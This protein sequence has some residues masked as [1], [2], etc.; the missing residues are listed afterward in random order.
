MPNLIGVFVDRDTNVFFCGVDAV[1][2]A[3]L[4]TGGMLGKDRKIDAVAHPGRTQRIGI[5]K[6]SAYRGHNAP[7][8]YPALS[9]HWQP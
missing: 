8:I 1:E 3:K 7:R 9:A 6:K 2:Q 5:A 4:N